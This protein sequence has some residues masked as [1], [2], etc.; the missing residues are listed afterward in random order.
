MLLLQTTSNSNHNDNTIGTLSVQK[1]LELIF[2]HMY[3]MKEAFVKQLFCETLSTKTNTIFC[4]V[5]VRKKQITY[6]HRR[7]NENCL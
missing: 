3:V 4:I 2:T 7:S 6:A 1:V 5:V